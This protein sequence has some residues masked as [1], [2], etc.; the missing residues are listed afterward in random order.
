M[1]LQWDDLKDNWMPYFM[2]D[3][4]KSTINTAREL[5]GD[6]IMKTGDVAILVDPSGAVFGVQVKR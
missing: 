6:L 1:E 2:V 5:G 4:I 3:D